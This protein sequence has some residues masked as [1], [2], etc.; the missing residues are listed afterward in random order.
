MNYGQEI[1]R[2]LKTLGGT[3]LWCWGVN[4]FQVLKSEHFKSV[5]DKDDKQEYSLD[6]LGGL[7]FKVKGHL[8]S[9][10][11]MIRLAGNDT[12]TV[13]I[14]NIRKGI[15]SSKQQVSN[16]YVDMMVDVINRMVET[17]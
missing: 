5:I 17:K 9:G 3:T 11:V 2:Q 14:G 13:D 10:S 16:V 15:F 8:H 4:K 6:H 1:H 7:L 12:Y